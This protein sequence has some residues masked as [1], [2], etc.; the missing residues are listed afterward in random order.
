MPEPT[1]TLVL[2][3][4]NEE[5]RLGSALDELFGY[6]HRR[7]EQARDGPPGLRGAA[8]RHRR[9]RRGRR[10]HGRHRGA[11]A[12]RG[13]STRAASSSCSPSRTAARAPRSGRGCSTRPATSSSSPTP[14]WPRRPDEI[15]PLVEALAD[16]RRRLRLPDPAGRLG[17][18]RARSPAGAAPSARRSTCWRRSGWWARSRTRSAASR[19][20]AA[21]SPATSSPAR[22]S[23]A[24]CSTSR[25]SSSPAGAATRHAVVPIRW[26]DRRGLADA[27]G[28]AAGRPRRLGPV[29]DPADPPRRPPRRRAARPATASPADR[30][31]PMRLTAALARLLPLARDRGARAGARGHD[32]RR[33]RHAG[34]RLPRLPRRRVARARGPARVRHLVRGRRRLR[35]VLLPAHVHPAGPRRSGCCRPAPRPGPGSRCCSAAFA[36]GV[37]VLPVSRGPCAGSS[38]CWPACR[39]RS[40][41]RSSS[42]RSG[43]CCS[44]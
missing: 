15:V 35:A 30:R 24:S 16:R 9:P 31:S 13:R 7:G 29:P 2:P 23:P 17:H 25:S 37:A 19:A 4:Y 1:L 6:L 11:R 21:T 3:A 14:T 27:P 5:A 28:P 12:G 40:C 10:L 42:A 36:A 38:C 43:R 22:R 34:L 44:C 20:S 18:A 26:A 39:G 8:A 32:R 33:R 41:T